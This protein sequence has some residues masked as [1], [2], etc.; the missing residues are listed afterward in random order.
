MKR[1]DVGV[2]PST[3]AGIGTLALCVGLIVGSLVP[4]PGGPPPATFAEVA[5][6][7]MAPAHVMYSLGCT[8]L[9]Y[10]PRNGFDRATTV[11]P[12][13]VWRCEGDWTWMMG[14]VWDATLVPEEFRE[15][16]PLPDLPPDW[17]EVR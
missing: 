4:Q 13:E 10:Q 15:K 2:S 5:R 7:D 11:R 1:A 16:S 12:P 14:G 6:R 9:A 3:A 17:T 8:L